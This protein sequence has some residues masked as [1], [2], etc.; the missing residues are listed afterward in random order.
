MTGRNDAD[1]HLLYAVDD[2]TDFAIDTVAPG[3]AFQVVALVEIGSNIMQAIDSHTLK[4]TIHNRT[5]GT[6]TTQSVT[7]PVAAVAAPGNFN[8][9]LA[10][11]FAG[12]VA[13]ADGDVITGVGSYKA[14]AGVNTN[15][16]TA[17][18]QTFVLATA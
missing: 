7:A 5:T 13:G 16:S 12:G 14:T 8:A 10:V 1:I 9:R 15:F 6:F 3:Q 17:E 4:V 11:R 2:G 18:T